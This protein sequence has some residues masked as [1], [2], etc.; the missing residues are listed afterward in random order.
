MDTILID[1]LRIVAVVQAIF[2]IGATSVIIF[3]YIPI[4]KVAKDR[5]TRL[6][7]FHIIAIGFSYILAI[8][9]TCFDLVARY[10]SGMTWRL[11]VCLVAYGSGNLAL[12]LMIWRLLLVRRLYKLRDEEKA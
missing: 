5:P 2:V 3:R 1:V 11:P 7:T 9:S 8:I 6:L 10:N 12:W 4:V